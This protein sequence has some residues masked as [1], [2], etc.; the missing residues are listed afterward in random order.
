MAFG[1]LWLPVVLSAVA[2]FFISA[3]LHMALRYHRADHK[4]LPDEEGVRDAL[5]KSG[6]APGMYM[7]PYCK[8]QKQMSEPAFQEKFAKGPIAIVSVLPNGQVNMGKHLGLWFGLALLTSFT[9]GYVARVALQPGAG[10]A[11]RAFRITGAVAFGAYGLG[12]ISDSIWKA[13]P[14]SNTT[15]HLI[16]AIVYAVVTGA[17]FCTL[18]PK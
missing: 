15:R 2:V 8:D 12:Q 5:R 7:T 10:D 18:W 4:Q 13:Q 11:M 17:I 9:A 3:I 1:T 16:D 6:A 14:W